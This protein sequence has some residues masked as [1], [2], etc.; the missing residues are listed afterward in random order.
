MLS[1][2]ELDEV[3][4]I[5]LQAIFPSGL[6]YSFHKL[7]HFPVQHLCG[8]FQLLRCASL[9]LSRKGDDGGWEVRGSSPLAEFADTVSRVLCIFPLSSLSRSMMAE[10]VPTNLAQSMRRARRGEDSPRIY[11]VI[12]KQSQI[13]CCD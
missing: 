5:Q 8:L 4:L 1:T 6:R 12:S 11:D 2:A 3:S 13:K 9:S 10:D 7:L